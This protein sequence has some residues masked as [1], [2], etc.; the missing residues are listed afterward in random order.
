MSD[1]ERF[2]Y[3]TI[4][5]NDGDTA[6]EIFLN[7]RGEIAL[8]VFHTQEPDNL[9]DHLIVSVPRED[10]AVIIRKL[11]QRFDLVIDE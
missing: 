11:I 10:L 5:W 9:Q 3:D 1:R 2:H 8:D 4:G 7:G 6:V